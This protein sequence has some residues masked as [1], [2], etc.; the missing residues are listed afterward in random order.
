MLEKSIPISDEEDEGLVEDEG[1]EEGAVSARPRR[2][3]EVNA[4]TKTQPIPAASSFFLFSQTNRFYDF[5]FQIFPFLFI[6][7]IF[8]YMSFSL[9]STKF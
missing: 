1:A 7:D 6:F 5:K 3:S 8:R 9:P 2:M 4:A